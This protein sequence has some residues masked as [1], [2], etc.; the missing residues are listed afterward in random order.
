MAVEVTKRLFDVDEYHRMAQAGILSE[1]DRV[2]LVDGEIVA[3]RPIGPRHNAAVNRA[4][5]M[6][7][8]AVG[9][10]AIV[11]VQGSVR[12]HRFAEPQPDLVLLRPRADFYA[13]ALPGP[14][15]ILLVIEIADASVEYDREVK[16]RLYA[17]A[18]VPEYWLVNLDDRSVVCHTDP[19]GD[20]Y[21]T[22]RRA[23]ASDTI[24]PAALPDVAIPVT[25]LLAD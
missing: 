12:L 25:H 6:L 18:G 13:P 10:A 22:T 5:R 4:N 23:G 7:V 15:D 8:S 11:Q 24:A 17:Q 2:E 19:Q 21:R 14:S 9:E 1:D 20:A 16:A 3:M